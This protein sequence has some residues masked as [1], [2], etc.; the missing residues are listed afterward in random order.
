LKTDK[1]EKSGRSEDAREDATPAPVRCVEQRTSA[2]S[3]SGAEDLLPSACRQMKAAVTDAVFCGRPAA[4]GM[5]MLYSSSMAQSGPRFP[6]DAS[7]FGA[8]K[9]AAVAVS[10]AGPPF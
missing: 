9:S 10:S 3:I 5:V 2:L 1:H 4:L 6:A 8:L 7:W